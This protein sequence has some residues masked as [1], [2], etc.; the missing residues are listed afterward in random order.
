MP[1]RCEGLPCKFATSPLDCGRLTCLGSRTT[2]KAPGMSGRNHSLTLKINICYQMVFNYKKNR[3]WAEGIHIVMQAGLTMA[4]CIFFC[5]LIGLYLD[6]WLGTKGIFITIFIILGV[7]GGGVTVYRQIMHVTEDNTET[8][9]TTENSKN[10][11][12]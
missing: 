5:F 9:E 7:V 12:R 6:N 1:C 10:G 8:T 11:P 3:A 2:C 4:G